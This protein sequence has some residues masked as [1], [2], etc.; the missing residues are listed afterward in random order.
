MY[1]LGFAFDTLNAVLEICH[2]YLQVDLQ[3]HSI[4]RWHIIGPIANGKVSV[5][6]RFVRYTDRH[7]VFS[8]KRK[9]AQNEHGIMIIEALTKKCQTI[10]NEMNKLRR[11]GKLHSFW[12]FD[13]KMYAKKTEDYTRVKIHRSRGNSK[14]SHS[15]G[16]V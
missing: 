6:I 4:C 8:N 16:S 12:T 14:P 9:L 7:L 15:S 3:P 10:T 11:N 2:T 5:F 1:E 13:G